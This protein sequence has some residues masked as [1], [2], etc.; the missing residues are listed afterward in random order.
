MTPVL[1]GTAT[2]ALEH[3]H[4]SVKAVVQ[5]I[6]IIADDL[7]QGRRIDS[8]LL[9]EVIFFLRIFDR[10]CQ[11]AKEDRLLFPALEARCMSGPACP[12]ASLR[13]DHRK[14]GSLTLELVRAADAFAAGHGSANE[15]LTR[16]L[17][18]LA[19]LYREH[20]WKED[21]ILLPL[22]EKVLTPEEQGMLSQDFQRVESRISSDEVAGRIGQKAQRC[23]CHLGE[24]FI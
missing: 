5:T 12:I 1:N 4:Q 6:S 8:S 21:Y 16:T 11:T 22:A 24:V 14:A 23:Q 3:E 19:T 18:E 2:T 20:I 15:S 10:Q 9:T 7:E 17:R 13:D